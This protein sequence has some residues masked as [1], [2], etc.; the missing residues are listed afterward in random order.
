MKISLN[1]VFEHIK[2]ELSRIDIAQLVDTFIKTTAEIEGWK[3]VTLN[4]DKLTLGEVVEVAHDG[5]KVHS[6]ERNKT[7]TLPS[8]ADAAVGGLFMIVDA[9]STQKWATSLMLGGTKEM[10]LPLLDVPA[11]MRAGGWKSAIELQDYIIEVDNKSINSRPDLW[12]HRGLAREIAAMFDLQ[13]RPLS[14]FITQKDIV[15]H[16]LTAKADS[17]NPFIIDIQTDLCS[18]FAALYLSSVTSRASQLNMVVRLSRLDSRSINMFVD[19]TNYVMLDLGQ[20]MHAFDADVLSSKKITID[21]AKALLRQGFEGQAKGKL[22]LLDGETVEL[23]SDDIVIA[24]GGIA[25]S[26]AGIM[27]GAATRV[28]GT[29]TKLLLESAHFDAVT[30][31]R[32][33]ARHKKRTEASMRFEKSLDPHQNTDA[34]MRFLFLLDRAGVAYKAGDHIVSLGTLPQRK[35]I[36]VQHVFI[37]SRLGILIKPEHIITILEKIAFEVVQGVEDDAIVYI[38]TVPSFRATKD[39][40]IPEDIVEE[41]GRFIGY[42]TLPRVMPSLQLRP[43]DLRKTYTTR[44]IKSFFSYGLMMHELYGYSFFDESVLRELAW[45]PTDFVAIKNPISENYT[46]LVTTLQPHLLKAV[47]ENSVHHSQLRF[48]EWGR[49]WHMQGED[50]IEQ[51]SVSG[52]FYDASSKI[53]F[54]TGKALLARMFDELHMDVRWTQAAQ[55]FPWCLS[56]QTALL[57]HNNKRIGIAGMVDDSVIHSLCP[58]GG[59]A[60][61]FE[62]NADYFLEYKR[63]APR[64]EPLSKY[65]SVRRDVSMLIPIAVT[66]DAL[67]QMIKAVDKRIEEVTLIDF[68]T[69][70][71]WKDQKAMTFHVE[72]CDKEKTLV[73]DEVEGIMSR[74][75]TQLQQQGAVIR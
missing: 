74:V 51:K 37:E 22:L 58:A 24:D 64:F 75:I 69:K 9:G 56:Y 3:K 41:I 12:G 7:Y 66:T 46:R 70:P 33:S 2:G 42:D 31:R 48:Y 72:M 32:T 16:E 6:R 54:Y 30:I 62:I 1:W 65:P 19:A 71:E 55:D 13:L 52:I 17:Q 43:S 8:R 67:T 15:S 63:P 14:E 73:A 47:G 5:V 26:L 34:L 10:L 25:V 11:D 57:M 68:F 44:A 39:V 4:T 20:P 53:D 50:I 21:R 38:I 45:Q 23:T 40:K 27:G 61:I 36:T 28:I 59:A 29:T 18:R 49:V 60:F 35:V